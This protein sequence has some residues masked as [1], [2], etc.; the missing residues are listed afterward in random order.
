[1]IQPLAKSLRVRCA[2]ID[3]VRESLRRKPRHLV[4]AD[5]RIFG[6]RVADEQLMVAYNAD[7]VTRVSFVDR[8]A[9]AGEETL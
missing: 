9:F 4:K 8:L 6:Q 1:M 7:D 5:R 3:E 2:V